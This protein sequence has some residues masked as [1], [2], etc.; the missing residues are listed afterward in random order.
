MKIG[1]ESIMPPIIASP[2]FIVNMLVTF[3]TCKFNSIDKSFVGSIKILSK[4][5]E[6]V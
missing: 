2:N 3:N 5:S 4:E 6:K 1:I